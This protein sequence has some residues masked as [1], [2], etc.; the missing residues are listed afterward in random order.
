MVSFA[1]W[2]ACCSLS[3]GM[4]LSTAP[5]NSFYL[6]PEVLQNPDFKRR[7]KMFVSADGK[8]VRF[9]ITHRGDPASVDGIHHVAG[10][11]DTV[12][13][14]IKGTPLENAKVVA[15]RDGIDV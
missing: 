15:G 5:N 8:A 11:K 3:A 2:T 1:I 12:A 10:I 7:L 13:E 9:I 6:P 4:T 14:A